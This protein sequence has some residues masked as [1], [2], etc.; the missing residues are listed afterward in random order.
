MHHHAVLWGVRILTYGWAVDCPVFWSGG[1]QELFTISSTVRW[2]YCNLG[3][4][5]FVPPHGS[6]AQVQLPKASHKADFHDHPPCW[7]KASQIKSP[8]GLRLLPSC[9][10]FS[11]SQ[12]VFFF[13]KFILSLY[14]AADTKMARET[15]QSLK[16]AQIVL[17]RLLTLSRWGRI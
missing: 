12:T 7:E 3:V 5:L 4:I 13:L 16:V 10:A 9:I 14:F 15:R 11:A 17:P 8:H 6:L 2:L 1:Q